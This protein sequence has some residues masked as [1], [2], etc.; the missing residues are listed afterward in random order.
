MKKSMLVLAA[1]PLAVAGVATAQ[2]ARVTIPGQGQGTITFFD[3]RDYRGA[4]ATF[5]GNENRVRLPFN[6]T[7][8]IR[9][10]GVW[11]VCSGI[12][13]TARGIALA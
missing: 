12:N 3:A 4:A 7:G 10:E 1:V 11:R 9:V 8:S 6:S 5:R 2:D 13:Y